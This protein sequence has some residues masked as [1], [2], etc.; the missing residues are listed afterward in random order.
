MGG[1]VDMVSAR[2]WVA[3]K[4]HKLGLTAELGQQVNRGTRMNAQGA[5]CHEL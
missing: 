3:A 4:R 5:S 1:K 2:S